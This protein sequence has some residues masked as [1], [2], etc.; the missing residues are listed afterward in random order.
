MRAFVVGNIALDE[1]FAVDALPKEGESIFG[2]RRSSDLGGKGANQAVMLA[3]C[4]TSVTLIAGVGDDAAADRVRQMLDCEPLSAALRTCPNTATDM[5][6]ILSDRSGANVVV[7]TTD[8]AKAMD[9]NAACRA[10]DD[11]SQGDLLV[12]QGNLTVTANEALMDAAH[13][14]NMHVAFNPSPVDPGLKPLLAKVNTLFLNDGE[15]MVLTGHFGRAAVIEL[16]ELGIETVVLTLG[17]SGAFLGQAN[18]VTHVPA[19]KAAVLDTTGAGDSYQGVA[20]A[21]AMRN[22][23]RVS[24]DDLRLAADA[25]ALTVSRFGSVSAMPSIPE[26]RELL[27]AHEKGGPQ[28]Q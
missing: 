1:T 13:H 11:A 16:L 8:C 9:S 21:S 24:D 7:T 27:S 5:S 6:V 19:G 12:L 3:R 14:R 23:R 20:L 2:T 22:A 25:A 18:Q 4:G 17:E 15:A 26:I 10:L 28:T